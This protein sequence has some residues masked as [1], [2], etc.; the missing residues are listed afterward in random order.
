MPHFP[1]VKN[2]KKTDRIIVVGTQAEIDCTKDWLKR[3][4]AQI[5]VEGVC[6]FSGGRQLSRQEG[7][8]GLKKRLE[9]ATSSSLIISDIGEGRDYKI[10]H[11]AQ[12]AKEV[13][14]AKVGVLT[15]NRS[16]TGEA[17]VRNLF[18]EQRGFDPA[19]LEKMDYIFN[20][21]TGD[22][23]VFWKLIELHENTLNMDKGKSILVVED[24][25][26]YYT[27]FLIDLDRII[28]KR[29]RILVARTYEQAKSLISR[30]KN[31]LLGAIVDVHF[32][33]KSKVESDSHWE[34]YYMIKGQDS[35]VPIIFQSAD[36]KII[37]SLKSDKRAFSLWKEDPSFFSNLAATIN[38]Y[39]GFGDFVFVNPADFQQVRRASSLTQL[40]EGITKVEDVSILY[41]AS[42][43][44][45]SNWLHL[46][47][48]SEAASKIKPISSPD[49]DF[50]RAEL[51]RIL[52]PYL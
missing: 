8:Y 24:R 3:C 15:S 48:Y 44:H 35:K 17:I 13:S 21:H 33:K 45:F 28:E 29:S 7:E 32:P 11:I 23:R 2:T 18:V 27:N 16:F 19:I 22:G 1:L 36:A 50:V 38:D 51:L 46:H 37:R 42:N 30:L 10:E 4:K 6:T 39:F 34:I 9:K 40:V 31:R 25:P 5:Q 43:N 26:E 47:G 41:H 12:D 20:Y 49:A 52:K 14:D